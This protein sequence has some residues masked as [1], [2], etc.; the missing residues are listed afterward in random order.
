MDCEYLRILSVIVIQDVDYHLPGIIP[1]GHSRRVYS[2]I[3][4][5]FNYHYRIPP[6]LIL[7]LIIILPVHHDQAVS[8]LGTGMGGVYLSSTERGYNCTGTLCT[9]VKCTTKLIV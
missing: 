9:I 7:L 2:S 4:T 5:L 8:L 6:G 3:L 1:V